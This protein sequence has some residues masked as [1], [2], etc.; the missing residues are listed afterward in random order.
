MSDVSKN[1]NGLGLRIAQSRTRLGLSQNNVSDLIGMPRPN[2]TAIEN[3]TDGRFLKDYQLKRIATELDVSSDYL[4]GLISD[5][6]P[7]ADMMSIINVLGISTDS[8]EFIKSLNS[9]SH[10]NSLHTLDNFIGNSNLEFWELLYL[11]KRVKNFYTVKY[12]FVLEFTKD[13]MPQ[14]LNVIFNTLEDIS[15]IEPNHKYFY[16][17]LDDARSFFEVGKKVIKENNGTTDNI[18]DKLINLTTNGE[19][20]E[21]YIHLYQDEYKLIDFKIALEKVKKILHE[22]VFLLDFDET[23]LI[24]GTSKKEED[25][26]KYIDE[27]ILLINDSSTKSIDHLLEDLYACLIYFNETASYSL[28]FIKYRINDTFNTYLEQSLDF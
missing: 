14:R 16:Y 12:N 1:V 28:N 5:P 18:L 10:L 3:E 27:L 6:N 26:C 19:Y 9:Y 11:Y 21:D 24:F 17:N 22:L 13:I 25:I 4:L 8:I 15:K 20:T 7:N 2:Y 23:G